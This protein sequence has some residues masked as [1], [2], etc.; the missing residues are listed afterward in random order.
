[1]YKTLQQQIQPRMLLFLLSSLLV[2]ALMASYLYIIKTPLKELRESRQTLALLNNEVQTGIPVQSQIAMQQQQ[3]QELTIKLKGSGPKLP[4]NKMVAYVIGEL[5]KLADRYRVNLNHVQPENPEMLF[6]F[7]ELPFHV[8]I[9]GDYFS[10]YA[11]L[12]A[13]EKELG[14]VIIKQFKLSPSGQSKQR[15][16]DLMIVTYQFEDTP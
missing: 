14:P 5:D 16:M 4:V 9:S 11:W 12:K 10:L 2:L 3:V 8:E 7:K 1:V 6:T 13:I 15:K